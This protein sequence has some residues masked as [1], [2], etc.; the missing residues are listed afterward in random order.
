MTVNVTCVRCGS[1]L[2]GSVQGFSDVLPMVRRTNSAGGGI[3]LATRSPVTNTTDA[4][5]AAAATDFP[6]CIVTT[7][8]GSVPVAE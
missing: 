6:P 2:Q 3:T 4:I 8:F 1:Y 5:F 7:G